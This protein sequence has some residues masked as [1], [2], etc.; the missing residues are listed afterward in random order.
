MRSTRS[1][2]TFSARSLFGLNAINFFQAEMVGVIL[3]IMSVF[4]REHGWR[5]DSIGIA[6]AVAGLG[7]LVMQT[8]AGSL[9]DRISSR[10]F[11]FAATSVL[12]GVCFAIVPT[13][14][15]RHSMVDALL[16]VSGAFQS[17]FAPLLGALA[18]ALV[19]HNLLN[20]TAGTNQGWNHAGNI[21]AAVAAM[22]LVRWLGVSS[23]FY[24]VGVS[25]L[26]AA[27]SVLM[28]R[29]EDLDERAAAGLTKEHPQPMPWMALLRDRTILAVFVSIFL[30][31]L[32]N[33]PILPTTALYVKQLGGSDS[34]MTATVLTA[35]IVMV[36]VAIFAG[37]YGD[38]W[39]R[40]PILAI[41]FWI[42]PL[43][44]LSY[45]VA[46]DPKMVVWLQGLDGIGAGIYGVI[47][48]SLAADLTRGRGRFNTLAGLFATAVAVGGVVGPVISGFM[49]QHAGFKS[50]FLLFAALALAGAG[51]FT[52]LVPETKARMES[53]NA[54]QGLQAAD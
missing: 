6:T 14:A 45:I 49:V 10:R 26:A 52:F 30:F 12:T 21:V 11:L 23:V 24:A 19:G 50:T 15:G 29:S 25:S 3:P 4:F 47:V 8:P 43:R 17:F 39:G 38:R 20:K 33:A 16:F 31:H 36:P 32:A 37:R 5:Y 27:A 2:H 51:I 35:Q 34:L 18:L 46:R 42:L 1:N 9:C 44:I 53:T 48:I 54:M 28:I 22:A 7:T 41:A 13:V 40:K